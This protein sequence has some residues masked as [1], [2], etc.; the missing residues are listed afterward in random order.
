[1]IEINK[2]LLYLNLENTVV[3]NSVKI[4]FAYMY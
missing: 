4:M 2:V 1:M 3:F